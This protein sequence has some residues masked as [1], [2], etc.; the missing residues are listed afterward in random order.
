MSEAWKFLEKK[1]FSLK[2]FDVLLEDASMLLQEVYT[3]FVNKVR[4]NLTLNFIFPGKT[5]ISKYSSFRSKISHIVHTY[6]VLRSYGPLNTAFVLY[7]LFRPFNLFSFY[8]F[9]SFFFA[10]LLRLRFSVGSLGS[11]KIFI[12]RRCKRNSKNTTQ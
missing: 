7:P 3:Q 6:S 5:T 12:N 8:S 10:G 2:M 9:Y 1:E 11:A 4:S